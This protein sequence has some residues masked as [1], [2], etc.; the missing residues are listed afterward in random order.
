[1]LL[2]TLLGACRVH[3]NIEIGE[4]VGN[5]LIDL[6]SDDSSCY[7]PLVNLFASVGRWEDVNKLRNLMKREDSER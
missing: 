7:V 6:A 4:H 2:K 1:M 5:R 3:G